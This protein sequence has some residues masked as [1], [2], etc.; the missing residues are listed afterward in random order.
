MR[1]PNPNE[2]PAKRAKRTLLRRVKQAPS[3]PI[4]SPAPVILSS[5]PPIDPPIPFKYINA[6]EQIR[7]N[8]GSGGVASL[9]I[10]SNPSLTGNIQLVAGA[11]ITLSQVGQVVTITSTGSLGV[12]AQDLFDVLTPVSPYVLTLTYTPIALSEIISWNGLVL[13][14]GSLND[15]VISGNVIT[16]NISIVVKVGDGFLVS[17]Q[18]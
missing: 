14:P 11:N 8:V 6:P 3:I 4:S 7:G 16:L 18:H 5:P 13:R 9:Q 1:N 15:Y 2:T 12:W 17:Y 10:D